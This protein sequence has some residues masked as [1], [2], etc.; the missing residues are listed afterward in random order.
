MG[1]QEHSHRTYSP[2]RRA[3]RLLSGQ[4]WRERR[5]LR[6]FEAGYFAGLG[7]GLQQGIAAGEKAAT[8][9]GAHQRAIGRVEGLE[10]GLLAAATLTGER[11]V[12]GAL[13]ELRQD[14]DLDR[15][16]DGTPVR[17]GLYL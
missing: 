12:L 1:R 2:L 14:V 16:D 9:L 7:E 15:H 3:W 8:A 6:I 17:R 13:P 10:R 4:N 11:R 5:R